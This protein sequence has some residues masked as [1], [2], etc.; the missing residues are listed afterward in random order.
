[1]GA[2]D[3][4]VSERLDLEVRLVRALGNADVWRAI[5]LT[6]EQES[7]VATVSTDAALDPLV[8]GLGVCVR[9]VRVDEH[10][11]GWLERQADVRLRVTAEPQV[12]LGAVRRGIV[13]A[14]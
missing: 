5:S 10:L 2:P 12:D 4:G 14:V 8:N 6:V 13:D 9:R 11:P 7:D 3:G 1:M